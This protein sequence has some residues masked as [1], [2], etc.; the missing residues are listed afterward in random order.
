MLDRYGF[1]VWKPAL[2]TFGGTRHRDRYDTV[3]DGWLQ[4]A[5]EIIECFIGTD[6]CASVVS[7]RWTPSWFAIV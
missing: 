7:Q 1:D 5:A 4:R 2:S 3:I 6:I